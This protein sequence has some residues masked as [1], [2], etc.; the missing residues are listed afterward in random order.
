MALIVTSKDPRLQSLRVEPGLTDIDLKKK[1]SSTFPSSSWLHFP[2]SFWRNIVF[3]VSHRKKYDSSK[4]PEAALTGCLW[5][6][7]LLE[8]SYAVGP[9]WLTQHQEASC[10]WMPQVHASIGGCFGLHGRPLEKLSEWACLAMSFGTDTDQVTRMF[11]PSVLCP[12][13]AFAVL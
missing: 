3:Q 1:W 6:L 10:T 2:T 13:T 7:L 9:R 8:R 11:L 4:T 12:Y 5:M